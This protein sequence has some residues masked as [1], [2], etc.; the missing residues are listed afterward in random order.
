MRR[1]IS[2]DNWKYEKHLNGYKT[3]Y[4]TGTIDWLTENSVDYAFGAITILIIS[5]YCYPYDVRVY[6]CVS[7][8]NMLLLSIVTSAVIITHIRES[9]GARQHHGKCNKHTR[10]PPNHSAVNRSA[11]NCVRPG[12]SDTSTRFI[13]WRATEQQKNIKNKPEKRNRIDSAL[14]AFPFAASIFKFAM[15]AHHRRRCCRR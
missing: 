15:L 8:C 5:P 7:V 10:F 1:T 13:C 14:R 3:M 4:R 6:V 11:V 9:I 12:M 2:N